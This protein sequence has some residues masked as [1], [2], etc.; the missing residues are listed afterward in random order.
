MSDE[1]Y[2]TQQAKFSL[3][4]RIRSFRYAFTGIYFTVQ[5]Q[6]NMRIHIVASVLTMLLAWYVELSKLEWCVLLLVIGLVLLAEG[7]NTAVELLVDFISPDYHPKA[8]LIKDVASG[9]V[10]ITAIIA[11]II[12]GLIFL[13]KL[14]EIIW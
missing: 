8:G 5:T 13:P 1:P 9:A 12:G 10:L 6:Y 2:H 14:A 4:S 11:G 7:L 3:R